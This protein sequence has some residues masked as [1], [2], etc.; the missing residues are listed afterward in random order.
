MNNFVEKIR[1]SK[2]FENARKINFTELIK[3][4]CVIVFLLISFSSYKELKKLNGKVSNS[5][6][7]I[8]KT[9]EQQNIETY[10]KQ[11][12]LSV[13]GKIEEIKKSL[14]MLELLLTQENVTAMKDEIH[15]LGEIQKQF[16]EL[17]QL[18]EVESENNT[19]NK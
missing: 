2:S 18:E 1:Y 15:N 8:E 16:V 4:G 3:Y 12:L 10:N 19:K 6:S 9:M 11:M 7:S 17:L 14:G 5:N 13:D